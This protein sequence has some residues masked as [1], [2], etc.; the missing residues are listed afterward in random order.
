MILVVI[1]PLWK[2]ITLDVHG[3]P[4]SESKIRSTCLREAASAKAGEIRNSKQ[5]QITKIQISQTPLTPSLSPE[6]KGEGD[7]RISNF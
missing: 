1:K 4:S 5:I 7:I 2:F 6:G 3:V